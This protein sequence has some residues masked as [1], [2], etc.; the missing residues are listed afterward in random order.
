MA[1]RRWNPL[2]DNFLRLESGKGRAILPRSREKKGGRRIASP[3][4]F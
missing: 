2:F 1:Y 4:P 3:A